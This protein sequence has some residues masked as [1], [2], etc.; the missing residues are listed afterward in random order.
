MNLIYFYRISHWAYVNRIPLIPNVMKFIS[1]LLFN[2]VVPAS[3]KIGKNSRFMYGGIGCV[4][5]KKS[6]IGN[7]VCLGQGITIGRKLK[8][9]CPEIGNDVYIGAGA[10]IL[11]DIKVGNN[12]IIGANA[13]VINSIP[14]N[15]IVAGSPA[16]VV[17]MIEHSI[18]QELG[19]LL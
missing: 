6:I 11:G 1:F 15:S 8:E 9:S 18:W 14:D 10:R 13:V 12:I 4:I 7:N 19:D 17:K 5:H 3:V 16:K 2:S